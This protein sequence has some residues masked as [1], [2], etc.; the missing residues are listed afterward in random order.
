MWMFLGIPL[1]IRRC[2][3]KKLW[4]RCDQIVPGVK[5]F[6]GNVKKVSSHVSFMNID[7]FSLLK[8]I[9]WGYF[10]SAIDVKIIRDLKDLPVAKQLP[11]PLSKKLTGMADPK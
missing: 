8:K 4:P 6:E 2:P 5:T 10:A 3:C 9:F 1:E 7:Q 11:E